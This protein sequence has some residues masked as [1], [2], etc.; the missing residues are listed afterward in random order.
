[1]DLH[2]FKDCELYFEQALP[3]EVETLINAS[4]EAYGQ[5]EAEGLL[6]RAYFLAPQHLSVLVGLYRYY[7]YQH[8]LNDALIVAER[9]MAIAAEQLQLLPEWRHLTPGHLGQAAQRSFGLLRFY[10][11]ALKATTVALLR[12]GQVDESR[13]RLQKLTELDSG[14]RLGAARLLEVV[15]EFHPPADGLPPSANDSLILEVQHG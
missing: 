13:A 2:D 8:R 12:L 6:L 11:I 4:A 10:L 15:N 3:A 14:D 1:M 9:A 5:P 7:F